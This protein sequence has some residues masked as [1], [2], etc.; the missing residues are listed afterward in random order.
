MLAAAAAVL[1]VLRK[2]DLEAVGFAGH[3]SLPTP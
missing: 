2:S 3:L 1:E